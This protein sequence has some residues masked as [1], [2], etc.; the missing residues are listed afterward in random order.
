M[1]LRNTK[2]SYGSCAK[3]L[4]WLL[5]VLIIGM[6]A[7]GLYMESLPVGPGKFKIY[8]LHKSFGITILAL[9]ALRLVWKYI[10]ESP[11]LPDVMNRLEKFLARAGHAGALR[12][13]VRHAAFRLG[14]VLGCR[15]EGLGIWPVHVA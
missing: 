10:N 3:S 6:L 13:D 11:L 7:V 8:G 12:I 14:H 2:L 9:S 1:S 4:H 5:A 15:I